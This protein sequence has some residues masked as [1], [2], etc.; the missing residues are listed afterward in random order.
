MFISVGNPGTKVPRHIHKEGDGIRFI[1]GGSIIYNGQELVA[2]DWMFIPK[3][4]AYEFQVGPYGAT[5]G[6]C[7]ACCC[8]GKVALNFGEEVMFARP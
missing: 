6:Y 4:E 2:G 1:A 7:Y 3:G 8:A 5:M